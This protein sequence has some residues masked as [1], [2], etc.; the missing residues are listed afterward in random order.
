MVLAQHVKEFLGRGCLGECSEAAQVAEEAGDVGAVA[1]E[2]LLA[3][4][5]GDELCHLRREEAGELGS[6]SLDRVEQARVR[7]RDRGLVGERLDECDVLVGERP[8]LERARSRPRRSI[9]P[10]SMIGTPSTER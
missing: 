5:A 10:R 3:F 8:W 1:G 4:L 9:R 6:L 2:Q 7:D